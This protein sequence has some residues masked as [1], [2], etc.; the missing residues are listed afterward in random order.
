MVAVGRCRA[1]GRSFGTKGARS[2]LGFAEFI[3]ARYFKHG[4]AAKNLMADYRFEK[5]SS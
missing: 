2:P 3:I 1:L 5:G 4:F